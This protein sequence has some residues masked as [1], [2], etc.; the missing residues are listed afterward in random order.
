MQ[1]L[2]DLMEFSE[3]LPLLTKCSL[4]EDLFWSGLEQWLEQ[5][6]GAL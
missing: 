1:E 3:D 5:T 6:G 2:Y 4:P